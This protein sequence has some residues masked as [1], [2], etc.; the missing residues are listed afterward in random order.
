MLGVLAMRA[1]ARARE[2][3]RESQP[4]A[5]RGAEMDGRLDGWM[6]V[7]RSLGGDAIDVLAQPDQRCERTRTTDESSRIESNRRISH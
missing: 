5:R 7:L 6:L 1:R 3:E 4:Q 2:R